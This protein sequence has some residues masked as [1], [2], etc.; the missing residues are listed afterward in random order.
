M[1]KKCRRLQEVCRRFFPDLLQRKRSSN[2]RLRALQEV[3]GGFSYLRVRA[4]SPSRIYIS[5]GENLPRP[6]AS[7]RFLFLND[8]RPSGCACRRFAEPRPKPPAN[9]LRPP[10][11]RSPAA[12]LC[13]CRLAVRSAGL[14]RLILN[15]EV[16]HVQDPMGTAGLAAGGRSRR[17]RR[18]ADALRLG[19]AAVVVAWQE[20]A[21]GQPRH[22]WATPRGLPGQRSGA[23]VG[24]PQ[25]PR[26]SSSRGVRGGTGLAVPNVG[27]GFMGRDPERQ[28]KARPT[29]SVAGAVARCKALTPSQGSDRAGLAVDGAGLDARATWGTPGALAGRRGNRACRPGAR[30]TFVAVADAVG[31]MWEYGETTAFA[32]V[33]VTFRSGSERDSQR[34]SARLVNIT[35]GKGAIA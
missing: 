32:A 22:G 4:S 5:I 3:A 14:Q 30:V 11:G 9:L 31:N 10:A 24:E 16:C 12:L 7:D 20:K 28:L 8:E 1:I 13:S 33:R 18:L 35:R 19:D 25:A 21:P 26:P 27:R 2:I 6:P 34:E 15:L 29:L 23:R 17:V